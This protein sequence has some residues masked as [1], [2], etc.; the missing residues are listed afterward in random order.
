METGLLEG[1]IG[2]FSE[3]VAELREATLLRVDGELPPAAAGPTACPCL[4]PPA[5]SRR[6]PRCP[7]P[8]AHRHHARTVCARRGGN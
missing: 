1:L 6:A 3:Q 7:R 4:S 5:A 8:P 2:A